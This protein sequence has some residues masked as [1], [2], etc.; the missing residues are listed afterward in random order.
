MA[1]ALAVRTGVVPREVDIATLQQTL[2][3]QGV[4]LSPQ[5]RS[6]LG[7]DVRDDAAE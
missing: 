5:T 7:D 2:H 3:T 1:A 6:R 4:Y